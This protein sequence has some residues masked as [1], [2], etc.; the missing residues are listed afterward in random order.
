[1]A[2]MFT[3]SNT[4]SSSQAERSLGVPVLLLSSPQEGRPSWQGHRDRWR[5]VRHP[6]E[7]SSP[8]RGRWGRLASPCSW[9]EGVQLS[10]ENRQL[11]VV[12]TAGAGHMVLASRV[13][14]KLR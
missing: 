7:D 6:Q 13:L 11:P 8:V 9:Q 1:M 12:C 4:C 5:G 14:M 2:L 10:S 3:P